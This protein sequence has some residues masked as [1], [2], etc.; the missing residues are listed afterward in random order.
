MSYRFPLPPRREMFVILPDVAH[1]G[2]VCASF[3]KQQPNEET[4]GFLAA[5]T[6]SNTIAFPLQRTPDSGAYLL[7]VSFVD[8]ARSTTP[9]QD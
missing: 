8:L 9:L 1:V 4:S 6:T 3:G 2:V 5:S 7:N